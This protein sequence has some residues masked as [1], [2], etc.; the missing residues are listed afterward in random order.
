M[1]K[2]VRLQRSRKKGAHLVSPNGLPIICVSRPGPYGNLW[3]VGR[4]PACGCRSAD[5]PHQSIFICSTPKEAVEMF[6]WWAENRLKNIPH[7]LDSI[8]NCNVADW[9]DLDQPCHGDVLLKLA[10]NG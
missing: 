5:C 4:Q 9:C 6:R 2:A 3:R 8:R 10:N 1:A 7:W